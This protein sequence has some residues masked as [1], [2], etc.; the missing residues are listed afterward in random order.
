MKYLLF[1]STILLFCACQTSV[2]KEVQSAGTVPASPNKMETAVEVDS[3]SLPGSISYQGFFKKA[4]R[5][6]DAT[7]ENLLLLTETGI[8]NT[9]VSLG[10]TDYGSDAELY[11]YHYLLSAGGGTEETWKV[12]DFIEDCPVD[13]VAAFVPKECQITDLN[14]NGTAEIWL[15]YKTACHGDVSPLDMKIIMYE[16]GQKYALR[17]ENK[18]QVGVLDDGTAQYAGGDYT[19]D[20]A[21]EKGPALFRQQALEIWNR[22]LIDIGETAE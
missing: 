6:T 19:F 1:L 21:F 13:I 20:A 7:G 17:G 4:L 2:Q 12:Y 5:W 16:G 11:A 3:G 18:V 8:R 15:L 9:K 14:S 10:E 22:N